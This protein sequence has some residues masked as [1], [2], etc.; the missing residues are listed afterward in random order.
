MKNEDRGRGDRGALD[1]LKA[2][3]TPA[4]STKKEGNNA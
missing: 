2:G 1:A 4:S 3:S